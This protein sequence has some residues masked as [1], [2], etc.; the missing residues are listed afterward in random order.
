[1]EWLLAKGAN[2]YRLCYYVKHKGTCSL[3]LTL[4]L[5]WYIIYILRSNHVNDV[6]HLMMLLPPW[7]ASCATHLN[8]VS[9]SLIPHAGCVCRWDL[10]LPT[11]AQAFRFHCF[12]AQTPRQRLQRG[13]VLHLQVVWGDVTVPDG[14]AVELIKEVLKNVVDAHASQEATL[15][16]GAVEALRN[17]TLVAKRGRKKSKRMNVRNKVKWKT[18]SE[19][20]CWLIYRG[21]CM[22]YNNSKL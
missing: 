5:I 6:T 7:D 1:M 2:N 19:M 21:L 4:H 11:Y 10:T 15:L 14:L 13:E 8:F 17:K 12:P 18:G 9:L 16:N 20:V 3:S 22:Q